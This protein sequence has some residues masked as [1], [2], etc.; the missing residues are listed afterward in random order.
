MRRP[1]RLALSV[2][3]AALL[4]LGVTAWALTPAPELRAKGPVS[5]TGTEASGSFTMGTATVRQVRYADRSTLGYRFRLTNAGPATARV[6]GVR[7]V[8]PEA[9]LLRVRAL[10]TPGGGEVELAPDDTQEVVLDVLMTDCERL[11]ARAASL[12]TAVDVEL[13]SWGRTHVVRV[14]LPEQ[15]RTGSAREMFCPRATA[16]TRPP[17]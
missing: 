17:G 13:T 7:A 15:L 4:F 12:V 14:D 2:G 3:L 9:T 8:G 5:V 11:S 1:A 6:V 10:H 16:D